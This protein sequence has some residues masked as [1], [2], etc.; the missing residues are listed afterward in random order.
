MMANI[1]G[2]DRFEIISKAKAALIEGTNI[3]T[4]TKERQD[5]HRLK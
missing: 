3:E 1:C 4:S 5:L 2:D